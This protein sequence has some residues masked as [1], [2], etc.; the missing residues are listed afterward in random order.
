MTPSREAVLAQERVE[1]AAATARAAH[2]LHQ[3]QGP[4]AHGAGGSFGEPG[5]VGQLAHNRL[6]FSE[7]AG[8]DRPGDGIRA[9]EGWKGLHGARFY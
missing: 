9:I 1:G 5:L 4:P 2:R 7:I 6:F 8:I 3:R